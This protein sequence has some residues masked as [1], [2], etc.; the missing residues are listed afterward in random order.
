LKKVNINELEHLGLIYCKNHYTKTGFEI[1]LVMNPKKDDDYFET[2]KMESSENDPYLKIFKK[3][4]LICANRDEFEKTK[5]YHYLKLNF[6]HEFADLISN[7][8]LF[9]QGCIDRAAFFTS[10]K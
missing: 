10:N 5:N 3:N 6:R 8:K 4:V 7:S 2:Y 9:Q 1:R